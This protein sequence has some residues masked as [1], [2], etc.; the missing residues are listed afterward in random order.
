MRVIYI[1]PDGSNGVYENAYVTRNQEFPHWVDVVRMPANG[2]KLH[3]SEEQI[4]AMLPVGTYISFSRTA[5]EL[6]AYEVKS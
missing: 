5:A 6:A 2:V 4:I 1:L 3:R